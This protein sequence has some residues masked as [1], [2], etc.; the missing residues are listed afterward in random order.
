[1]N[2]TKWLEPVAQEWMGDTALRPRLPDAMLRN[3]YTI[4]S[5][6]H[7]GVRRKTGEVYLNHPL[8]VAQRIQQAGFDSETIMIA[9]MHD[10]VEDSDMTLSD[11]ARFGFTER[12]VTG[13]DSVTKRLGESYP[14]AVARA[15]SH[16]DGRIVKLADNLDNSSA[17]QLLPFTAEKREKQINKYAP[18]RLLLMEAITGGLFT[19]PEAVFT[20]EYRMKLSLGDVLQERGRM[21]DS[22]S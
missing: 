2:T 21:P 15:A 14:E 20:Q 11:L 13:V 10:A 16:P 8:R 7:A 1:M 19:D 5:N 17:E 9:L 22:Y 18:A 12:V 3:A 4:A 6:A